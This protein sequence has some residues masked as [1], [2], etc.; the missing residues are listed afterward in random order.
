[1]LVVLR[2]CTRGARGAPTTC[3]LGTAA[4][5]ARSPWTTPVPSGTTPLHAPILEQH[6][7]GLTPSSQHPQRG[8]PF[9]LAP[10]DKPGRRRPIPSRVRGEGTARGRAHGSGWG[11]RAGGGLGAPTP[12]PGREQG[13]GRGV[14]FPLRGRPWS[15]FLSAF[16]R[17]P[18]TPHRPQPARC[19]P[20]LP[21]VSRARSRGRAWGGLAP[22]GA[23]PSGDGG[24]G[25]LGIAVGSLGIVMGSLGITVGPLGIGTG[26]PGITTEGAGHHHGGGHQLSAT[27]PCHHRLVGGEELWDAAG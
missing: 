12:A 26:P 21:G 3:S 24:L 19:L 6:F 18:N 9:P 25:G 5:H 27:S 2:K 4:A 13:V 11:W 10:P 1:M 8:T 17:A 7:E 14:C 20:L 15:C 22:R 16:A 23:A